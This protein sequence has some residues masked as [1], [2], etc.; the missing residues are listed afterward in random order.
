[1]S[2]MSQNHL[3]L[4]DFLAQVVLYVLSDLLQVTYIY[5]SA[6]HP[7]HRAFTNV[8]VFFFPFQSSFAFQLLQ[9]VKIN[10]R[11]LGN[12]LDLC[13]P[14]QWAPGPH[15]FLTKLCYYFALLT[16]QINLHW[17]CIIMQWLC[18]SYKMNAD[19]LFDV[20]ITHLG[21][22]YWFW[23][24][25]EI[26]AVSVWNTNISKGPAK[27]LRPTWSTVRS[28]IHETLS[29]TSGS[30]GRLVGIYQWTPPQLSAFSLILNSLGSLLNSLYA[31][32]L[33]T[34]SRHTEFPECSIYQPESQ[35]LW[36]LM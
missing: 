9:S 16:L 25:T 27:L 21:P 17:N 36:M 24:R 35:T 30:N 6:N 19:L 32:R 26:K 2:I 20:M 8:K 29:T 4:T 22:A 34:N 14:S 28:C 1:M 33:A 3:Y 18:N 11:A 5:I 13:Y 7:A 15:L 12:L 10:M 23:Y 31:T